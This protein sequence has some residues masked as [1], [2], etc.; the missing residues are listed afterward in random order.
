MVWWLLLV[1]VALMVWAAI[2]FA[3]QPSGPT[4]AALIR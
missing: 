1:V 4:P 2:Q 3:D